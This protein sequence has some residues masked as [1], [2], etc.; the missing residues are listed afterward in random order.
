MGIHRA[1]EWV[2]R[3][4]GARRTHIK[5][6]LAV[7]ALVIALDA[8]GAFRPVE[9][10]LTDLHFTWR[11]RLEPSGAV[12]V[13][14]ISPRCMR[15]LGPWPWP[16]R[17]H[18]RL[19]AWLKKAGARVICY[20][21]YFPNPSHEPSDDA[22]M[23]KAAASAGNVL[24]AVYNRG[25]LDKGA[26][27]HWPFH[28][29]ESLAGNIP[30][31][32]AA[33]SQGHIN[34][35]NDR[36]GVLR[37]VPVGLT[38]GGRLYYQLA[39][40]AAA[41]YLGVEEGAIAPT[42]AGLHLGERLVPVGPNGDLL[43]NY[44]HVPETI[45][46]YFVSQI[47]ANEVQPSAFRDKLVIIGQT[48]H[49]LQNADLVYTPEGERFG[50][51][52]QAT[53][54]DNV[55]S[56]R[57]LRR[58]GLGWRALAAV[59]LSLCCA[60]RLFA[61]RLVG[62][63][64]WSLGFAAMAVLVSHTLFERFNLLLD[65][66]PLLAVVIGGNLYGALAF[67]MVHANRE[68]RRREQEL[69]AVSEA[70]EVFTTGG[71]ASVLEAIAAGIG[72]AVGAEGACLFLTDEDGS[73]PRLAASWGFGEGLE[74]D[75]AADA[76]RAAAAWA[77]E[78][79]QPY[80][81]E[82]GSSIAGPRWNH[83]RVR[84][85]LI[86]P[87]A[88]EGEVFGCLGL[89][90]KRAT[91]VSPGRRFS[92]DDFR[93]V[94]LLARQAAMTVE[95]WRLAEHLQAALRDL[96]AAQQKLIESERLSAVGRVANMI[97]HD[98]KS[99]MQG[100]RMFAEMC[101]QA[102]LSDD[103]RREFSATMCTEIDRLVGM[104]QEILDFARGTTS[105]ATEQLALDELI[106]QAVAALE[107][108]AR[109]HGVELETDLGFADIVEADP[110]RLQRVVRN[111]CVNAIEAMASVPEGRRHLRVA[112]RR[113]GVRALIEVADTGPGIPEAIAA[114]V[115]EPFVTEGKEHGTG[116]GLAI[117]R[118]V[119]EDHGGSI[120]F[121]STPGQ[122]TTFVVELPASPVRANK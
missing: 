100:I 91:A 16:R 77:I 74:A 106:A 55:I 103:D 65:L 8:V 36:H 23:A 94:A 69:E 62:K 35:R 104:C 7:A 26:A 85:A 3:A 60:S 116:L 79:L 101:A 118:K 37:S 84:S 38:S 11:G 5:W 22:A 105:L 90:G 112:T 108:Q 34:V 42:S 61:R 20:D 92:A 95:R 2:R 75:E 111:L 43:V 83:A 13:V 117:A 6:G 76:S 99:P 4:G 14:G 59:V 58:A 32:T 9:P 113:R 121:H 78:N 87:L 17:H 114:E 89:Y 98:I 93:L 82:D 54:A 19:I 66:T 33:T 68:A 40:L 46:T 44:Y 57:M 28:E 73:E 53:I 51:Y 109:E 71:G 96:E 81:V 122:V 80:F 24:L 97:I 10:L 49:G 47:L 102:D 110:G 52:V 39:V 30:Q 70:A 12:V 31:L 63:I 86:V 50:V 88:L 64:A 29:V 1:L 27:L 45:R 120:S 41:R 119:V 21:V 56:G 48:H 25:A 115:F 18:A 67:G 72:R 107:V 15:R